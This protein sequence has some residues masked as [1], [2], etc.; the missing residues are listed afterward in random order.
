M[1][2]GLAERAGAA[3]RARQWTVCAA[4]SCTGGLILSWLTDVPG[5]SDYVLGGVV[6]YANS[7][8]QALLGVS[9]QTLI[10]Q[11]AVSE[12]TAAEMA[13]GVRKAFGADVAV[14]VT[15][16]AGPGGGTP[17]KPVGLTY[18]GLA[19][20]GGVLNVERHVWPGDRAAVRSASAVRV[21]EMI[22][23]L[24]NKG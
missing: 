21:L 6:A 9:E 2:Q 19:G 16:I 10:S 20:P 13:L 17:D 1:A 14:S 15:G 24:A 22:L 5:S 12:A 11:G 23:E 4:E 8:K 18:L 3:L 7:A